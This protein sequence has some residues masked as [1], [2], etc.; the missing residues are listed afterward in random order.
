MSRRLRATPWFHSPEEE[1]V[2]RRK[3]R[4]EVAR[5]VYSWP[6]DFGD[7]LYFKGYPSAIIV[8]IDVPKEYE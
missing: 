7:T 1:E 2:A 8:N 6:L 3:R 5:E 4:I